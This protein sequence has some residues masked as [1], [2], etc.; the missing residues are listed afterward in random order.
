[1]GAQ[2]G[3]KWPNCCVRFML[4]FCQK[5][6]YNRLSDHIIVLQWLGLVALVCKGQ[7]N[8]YLAEWC[9]QCC[10][11]QRHSIHTEHRLPLWHA[12][13]L[14]EKHLDKTPQLGSNRATT[15]VHRLLFNLTWMWAYW[16][17]RL[18]QDGCA[19]FVSEWLWCGSWWTSRK[20]TSIELSAFLSRLHFNNII[21]IL[22]PS[23][24]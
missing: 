20:R 5:H 2:Q 22:R 4:L 14:T 13:W 12:S 21:L 8:L 19:T 18:Y 16:R 6:T 1:M 7:S 11:P 9:G 24:I 23:S 17:S 10:S 15:E 3:V